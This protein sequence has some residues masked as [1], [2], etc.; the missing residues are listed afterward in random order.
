L[1]L[2]GLGG[3]AQTIINGFLTGAVLG[4][5]EIKEHVRRND[6]KQRSTFRQRE[7]GRKTKKYS[8]ESFVFR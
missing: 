5:M 8:L 2:L 1:K 6:T 4:G 7:W 3:A